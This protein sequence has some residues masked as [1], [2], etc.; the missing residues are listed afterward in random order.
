MGISLKGSPAD[1]PQGATKTKFRQALEFAR[2]ITI[3][4]SVNGKIDPYTRNLFNVFIFAEKGGSRRLSPAILRIKIL[5]PVISRLDYRI[6][7]V[8]P[9]N[10]L[11]SG[12]ECYIY[13]YLLLSVGE[14][15]NWQEIWCKDAES[16]SFD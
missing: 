15:K 6:D 9:L 4:Y 8:N 12:A 7:V 10:P 2:D 14:Q 16:R 3:T 13:S 11:P 5:E 1:I